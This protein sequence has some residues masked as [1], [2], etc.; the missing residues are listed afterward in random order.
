[1][2]DAP[3]PETPFTTPSPLIMSQPPSPIPSTSRGVFAHSE[4]SSSSFDVAST[5]SNQIELRPPNDCTNT[6][7]KDRITKKQKTTTTDI[8]NYLKKTEKK[9]TKKINSLMS[10]FG[11]M[12]KT[13]YPDVDV[14]KL[15]EID[16]D[17]DD[18]DS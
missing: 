18:D 10:V 6:P 11:Q 9:H 2:Y 3:S 16:D 13:D 17:S 12:V 1:M 5:N 7:K 8:F 14:S 15:I 4:S